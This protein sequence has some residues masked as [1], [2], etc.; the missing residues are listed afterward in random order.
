MN[1]VID[2]VG[3]R[4]SVVAMA[5]DDGTFGRTPFEFGFSSV[6]HKICAS[7][8]LDVYLLSFYF[9]IIKNALKKYIL[10]V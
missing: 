10:R 1:S 5:Y 7:L 3:S 9:M 6:G 8:W 4:C 2:G